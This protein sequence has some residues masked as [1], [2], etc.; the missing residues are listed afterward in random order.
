MM[1][2]YPRRKNALDHHPASP[3]DEQALSPRSQ[4]P[5]ATPI[6][7]WLKANNGSAKNGPQPE[8]PYAISYA[9][10][11]VAESQQHGSAKNGP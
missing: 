2:V 9:K 11:S 6:G 7:A 5:S 4:M 8:E 10:R 3:K 1:G